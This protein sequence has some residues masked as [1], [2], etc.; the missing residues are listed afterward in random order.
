MIADGDI[1][2]ITAFAA[3]AGAS[4]ATAAALRSRWPDYHF[5]YCLDD[6]VSAAARPVRVTEGF[7]LYLVAGAGGC[8][9]FVA[10]PDS[11]TGV[12]I[13]ERDGDD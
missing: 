2:A 8:I 12:V 11:A 4:D 1:D 7:N 3:D 10:S 9:G 5:T 6:D 13:A